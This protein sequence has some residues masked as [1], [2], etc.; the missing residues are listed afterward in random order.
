MSLP[1]VRPSKISDE[2]LLLAV[3]HAA[4]LRQLLQLLGI[5]AYGG[6]YEVVRARLA[7]AGIEDARFQA[8]GRRWQPVSFD[9][10]ASAVARSDS[11]ACVAR[12]V[13]WGES[14]GAQRRAKEQVL[15]AGLD[16]SHFLGKASRRGLTRPGS[17]ARS[18][19]EVLVRGDRLVSTASLRKRLLAEGLLL[20]ECATCRRHEWEGRPVPL[21][22]DHVNGDR[23]DNRLENLRLLCPNCHAQTDTYRGRNIGV[24]RPR[25]PEAPAA[26]LPTH[27][28]IAERRLLL[29][30]GREPS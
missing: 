3:P 4:N 8:Q 21:E 11:Y 9:K 29:V 27:A 7:A 22:L 15:A 23:K 1:N 6:N 30:L 16:V 19:A 17:Y 28:V 24:R 2:A 25:G 13:G 5:A 20:R 18:L 26:P 10:L 12:L 14:P